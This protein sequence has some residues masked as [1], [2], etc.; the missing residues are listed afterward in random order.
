MYDAHHLT[1]L[2]GAVILISKY[3]A[4]L[5]TL[6]TNEM[7]I[8]LKNQ[9][10]GHIGCSNGDEIYVVPMS[11]VYESG[12]IYAHTWDGKKVQY[13]RAR[14]KICFEVDQVSDMANWKTVMIQGEFEELMPG[15]AE[16]KHALQLLIEGIVPLRSSAI[17]RS[18]APE[19]PFPPKDL[20]QVNGIVF[21]IRIKEMTGRFEKEADAIDFDKDIKTL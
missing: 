19:W 15:S 4:M 9:V 21:R 2:K 3:I 17:A 11:Y 7:E 20:D 10:I 1:K 8:V 14:P 6:T 13:M 5:G 16:R 12:Y 18:L